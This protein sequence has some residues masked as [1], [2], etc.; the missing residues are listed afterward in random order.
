MTIGSSSEERV[1]QSGGGGGEG[2]SGG[3]GAGGG[4]GG[5][6]G[7]G[8]EGGGGG[9]SGGAGGRGGAAGGGCG[10]KQR[11]SAKESSM[12]LLFE[13][14]P[15]WVYTATAWMWVRCGGWGRMGRL[16][17]VLPAYCPT[18][19]KTQSGEPSA[20]PT[21]VARLPDSQVPYSPAGPPSPLNLPYGLHT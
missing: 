7:G 13:C 6:S 4:A 1:T 17:C 9:A 12:P 2:G 20:E 16:R 5:G 19:T 15:G 21:P 18:L 10:A 11:W 8:G 3:G 14:E